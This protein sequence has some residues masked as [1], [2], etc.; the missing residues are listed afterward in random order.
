MFVWKMWNWGTNCTREKIGV[1]L[2]KKTCAWQW[3]YCATLHQR[4]TNHKM[5]FKKKQNV[6]K[7]EKTLTKGWN[8]SKI[9]L[10]TLQLAFFPS[11]CGKRSTWQAVRS[12][13]NGG[14]SR[15][16]QWHLGFSHGL[17][18]QKSVNP[19]MS[20]WLKLPHTRVIGLLA[21]LKHG[22]KTW[23]IEKQLKLGFQMDSKFLS[24]EPI[25]F[26]KIQE[27]SGSVVAII[28]KKRMRVLS[29]AKIR[30]LAR[31]HP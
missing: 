7:R 14:E 31:C 20:F 28:I 27:I 9:C 21:K 25:F 24:S 5:H 10:K 2:G 26:D 6:Q 13:C 16:R 22:K 15:S 8:F 30:K 18:Y 1:F 29:L 12:C 23:K 4:S 19:I 17:P 11:P 3:K